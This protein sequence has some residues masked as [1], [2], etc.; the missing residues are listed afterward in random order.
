MFD[1]ID[2]SKA[3]SLLVHCADISHPAKEWNLHKNWTELLIEEFFRQGEKEAERQ[4]PISPL[5]DRKN[6]M[7][8]ESQI[9]DSFVIFSSSSIFLPSD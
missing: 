3:L 7:I 5:C 4:L 1:S 9:G 2:K 8:A 6:T